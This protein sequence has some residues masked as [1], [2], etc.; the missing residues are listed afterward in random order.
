MRGGGGT[1]FVWLSLD[2]PMPNIREHISGFDKL[3]FGY[4]EKIPSAPKTTFYNAS[5]LSCVHLSLRRAR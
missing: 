3:K 5:G 4:S 1:P 2:W